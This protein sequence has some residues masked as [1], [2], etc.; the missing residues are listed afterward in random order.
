MNF[1][2]FPVRVLAEPRLEFS[3]KPGEA[4]ES[5]GQSAGPQQETRTADSRGG[6]KH[7][8]HVVCSTRILRGFPRWGSWVTGGA[9]YFSEIV[10]DRVDTK[11][12]R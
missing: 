10:L 5:T 8:E 7:F 2:T 6:E 9:R 4:R 11:S 3:L 12:L 1:N